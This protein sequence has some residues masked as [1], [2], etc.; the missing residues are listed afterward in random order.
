MQLYI[1]NT[2]TL[3]YITQMG[4]SKSF[5]L[6]ELAKEIWNGSIVKNNWLSAVH[7]AG[8]LNA[9]DKHEWVLNKL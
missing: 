7:T 1:D 9:R 4:E 6:N 8:K 3:A 2:T 5:Q